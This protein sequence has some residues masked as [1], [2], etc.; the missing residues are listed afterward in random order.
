MSSAEAAGLAG[1]ELAGPYGIS[2]SGVH[3][4]TAPCTILD[5]TQPAGYSFRV[6]IAGCPDDRIHRKA[7]HH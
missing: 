4:A 7:Q 3:S 5:L 2:H 1:F 6:H